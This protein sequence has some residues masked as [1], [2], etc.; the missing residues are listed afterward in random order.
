[1]SEGFELVGTITMR[2]DDKGYL[3][4]VT[5]ID[6]T[7]NSSAP[8]NRDFYFEV[9]YKENPDNLVATSNTLT[10][11]H[12]VPA[13]PK[14]TLTTDKTE[15]IGNDKSILTVKGSDFTKNTSLAIK[16]YRKVDGSLAAI[17]ETKNAVTDEK[18]EFTLEIHQNFG[19]AAAIPSSRVFYAEASN[20]GNTIIVTSNEVTVDHVE[21]A[22]LP[23][24]TVDTSNDYMD[25][26]QI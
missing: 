13:N 4:I 1:M 10:I 11:R 12:L 21:M 14:L 7:S 15:V 17:V 26:Y 18:G 19:N 24:L 5:H 22:I 3:D 16:L 23:E 20:Q 9:A 6:K 25:Q 2:T 8:S